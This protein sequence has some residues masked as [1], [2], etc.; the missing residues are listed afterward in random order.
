[1]TDTALKTSHADIA[2]SQSAGDGGESQKAIAERVNIPFVIVNGADEPFVNNAFLN[3][4]NYANLW[5]GRIR[6]LEGLGRAPIWEAPE[7]F[8]PF[9]ERFLGDVFGAS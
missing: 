4:V 5:E 8:D 9:P 7:T 3:T 2:V 1:M 6:L